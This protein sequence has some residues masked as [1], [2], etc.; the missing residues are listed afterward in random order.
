M[1]FEYANRVRKIPPYLFAEIEEKVRVKKAQGVDIIDFGIGD[2]DIPTPAPIIEE[3]RRQVLDP[4]NHNYPSSAG[5]PEIR[6][7]I[8]DFYKRRFGVSL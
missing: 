1:V 6:Q 7:S 3:L 5:E 8:A 4:E 2:P